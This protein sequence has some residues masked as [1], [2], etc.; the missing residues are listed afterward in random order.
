MPWLLRPSKQRFCFASRLPT[1]HA[2]RP[3][4]S[5]R[6]SPAL[7]HG[8]LARCWLRLPYARR[9]WRMDVEAESCQ[10]QVEKH[11]RGA[12]LSPVL[13]LVSEAR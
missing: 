7:D 11:R 1:P 9:E 5:R 13:Y 4:L 8:P 2:P 6:L 3:R 12:I 10:L